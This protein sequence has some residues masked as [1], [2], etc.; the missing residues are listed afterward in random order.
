[1]IKNP[2]KLFYRKP[3]LIVGPEDKPYMHRWHVIPQNR[4]LN[5]YLHKFLNDDDDRAL[6]DHPW[7]SISVCLKGVY[8]EH[9]ADG[10][11]KYRHG[12]KIVYRAAEHTH[13]I[14]L[15]KEKYAKYRDATINTN[16]YFYKNSIPAWTLFITGPKIREWGFHCPKGWR[17]HTNFVDERDHGKVGRG[18]E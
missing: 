16:G 5:V 10:T 1:M 8:K 2:I 18:C 3:D 15:M 17:H 12:G 13:R 9:Y 7:D 6:H 4:Y 14:S 11:M